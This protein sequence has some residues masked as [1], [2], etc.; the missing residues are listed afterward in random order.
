MNLAKNKGYNTGDGPDGVKNH[1]HAQG[2][3]PYEDHSLPLKRGLRLGIRALIIATIASL[4]LWGAI[5]GLPGLSGVLLGAGIGGSFVLFTAVSVLLT[6][7]TTPSTTMAVVLGSWLLKIT[8]LVLVLFAIRD[9]DFYH[10]VS[11]F[12]TVVVVLILTLGT[13]VWAIVTSKVT[14]VG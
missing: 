9:L 7:N 2:L 14:F 4:V 10:T 13:E 5:A 12:V 11:L 3:S 6:A 8:L 1:N